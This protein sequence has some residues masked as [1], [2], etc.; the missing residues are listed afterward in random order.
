MVELFFVSSIE[1]AGP[2]KTLLHRPA[3]GRSV[4]DL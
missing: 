3:G 4:V 2:F 1:A